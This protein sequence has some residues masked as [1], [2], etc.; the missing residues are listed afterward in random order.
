MEAPAVEAPAV[1]APAVKVTAVEAPAVEAPAVEAPAVEAPA[2]EATGVELLT[3][4]NV[5]RLLV[6]SGTGNVGSAGS[7]TSSELSPSS[8]GTY[9]SEK[10]HGSFHYISP[11]FISYSSMVLRH[12][13]LKAETLTITI[14]TICFCCS[15]L[16]NGNGWRFHLTFWY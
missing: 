14:I 9:G 16:D 5:G 10:T 7:Y 12:I 13:I 15:F 8:G 4:V 3:V 6:V 1:E 2:V 11:L